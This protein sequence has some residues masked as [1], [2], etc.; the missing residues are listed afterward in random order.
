M[1]E[2]GDIREV[3]FIQRLMAQVGYLKIPYDLDA[4]G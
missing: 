1:P 3:T 2:M 4:I